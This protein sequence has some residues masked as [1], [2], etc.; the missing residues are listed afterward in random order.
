MPTIV[1][2]ERT[3]TT[4]ED[5][6]ALRRLEELLREDRHA[7]LVGPDGDRAELPEAALQLLRDGV[8]LLRQGAGV[9][10]VP[11]HRQL[12]TQQAADLLNVS[13]QYLTRLLDQGAIPFERVGNRRRLALSDVLS[14]KQKRDAERR[15]LLSEMVALTEEEGLY[16]REAEIFGPSG[17]AG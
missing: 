1:A 8:A 11:V 12:T 17:H 3:E 6:E 7:A 14:Y 9:S 5:M 4:P 10:L 16:A 2:G 13:R 15:R